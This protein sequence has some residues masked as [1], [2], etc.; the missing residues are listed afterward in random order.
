M[1]DSNANDSSTEGHGIVKVHFEENISIP[2]FVRTLVNVHKAY[3]EFAFLDSAVQEVNDVSRASIDD[4]H[5]GILARR[6]A[7]T[8]LQKA[9]AEEG[10]DPVYAIQGTRHDLR[11]LTAQ[12]S[13]SWI[14][15]LVGKLNP[16]EAVKSLLTFVRDWK[17]DKRIREAEHSRLVQDILKQDIANRLQAL[18]LVRQ[19]ADLL[20]SG[21]VPEDKVERFVRERVESAAQAAVL[22]DPGWKSVELIDIQEYQERPLLVHIQEISALPSV[23]RADNPIISPLMER[24]HDLG[25]LIKALGRANKGMDSDE[26]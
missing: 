3:A 5:W 17:T 1:T 21:G 12:P 24:S 11:I 4:E 7:A 2:L 20:R 26:R 18:E 8:Q 23:W 10:F 13:D 22:G 9:L 14:I 25:N 19:G 6:S 15:D 16:V